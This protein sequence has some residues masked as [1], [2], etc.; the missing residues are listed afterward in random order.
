MNNILKN[1]F[2]S[3]S[4]IRNICKY[5]RIMRGCPL[6]ND[7][8]FDYIMSLG[9]ACRPAAALRRNNLRFYSSP[10]D[11]MMNYS[12]STITD[13]FENGFHDFFINH[14][15]LNMDKNNFRRIQDVKTGMISMH[16]FP[17]DIPIEERYLQFF[18]IMKR[19]FDRLKKIIHN[20]QEIC[21]ISNRDGQV[22]NIEKFLL[23]MD[24]LFPNKIL[25]YINI[26]NSVEIGISYKKIKTNCYIYNFHFNDVHP[27]GAG[28]ENPKFW[29][30]NTKEWDKILKKIQ[31]RKTA[32]SNDASSEDKVCR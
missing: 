26:E 16:S 25:V 8:K 12:L 5:L 13:F 28:P 6:L 17:T 19:R 10:F 30:G 31:L 21:F 18:E 20:S 22:K 29:L 24:R 9:N 7:F 27:D 4:I 23:D 14:I 32:R 3:T 2:Y 11:W 1:S 15:D